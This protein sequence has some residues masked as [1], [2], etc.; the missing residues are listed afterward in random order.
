MINIAQTSLRQPD[1]FCRCA[2]L[3]WAATRPG[4]GPI[5]QQLPKKDGNFRSQG[6]D[7]LVHIHQSFKRSSP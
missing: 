2:A 4:S 5:I 3:A 6:V 7:D 1:R